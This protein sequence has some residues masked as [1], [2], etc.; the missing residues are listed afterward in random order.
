M[1]AGVSTGLI[2]KGES[3]EITVVSTIV[4]GGGGGIGGGGACGLFM[5]W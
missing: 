4:G 2:G 3:G 1:L 5:A